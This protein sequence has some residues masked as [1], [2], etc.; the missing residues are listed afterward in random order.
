MWKLTEVSGSWEL[1]SPDQNE[2]HPRLIFRTGKEDFVP[3]TKEW[4]D[5]DAYEW[6]EH[7]LAP[8]SINQ[9]P[10]EARALVTPEWL[11]D[12]RAEREETARRAQAEWEE[13]LRRE[14]EENAAKEATKRAAA[15]RVAVRRAGEALQ[16][17]ADAL[18]SLG[19]T[20]EGD[21]EIEA[22]ERLINKAEREQ[23]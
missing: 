16:D 13:S 21:D 9:L 17:L 18:N 6:R 12:R 15:K 22:L 20:S 23:K 5:E 2:T 7:E 11:A 10:A 19:Y 4:W 1:H 14:A 8:L 3:T